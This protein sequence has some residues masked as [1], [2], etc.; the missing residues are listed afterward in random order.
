MLWAREQNM[1]CPFL[2]ETQVKH[3]QASPF[4]K[5]IVQSAEPSGPERCS[6]PDHVNC[7][8]ARRAGGELPE[9]PRCPFL[10]TSLVQFCSAASITKYIPYSDSLLSRCGNE[11]HRYCDLYLG[12]ARPAEAGEAA[13]APAPGPAEGE[14][15]NQ[16]PSVD[17]VSVPSKMA[18]SPN[19]MW[20]D[21]GEDGS[22]HIGVDG[23]FA[24]VIGQVDRI[25][26]IV[27]KG[28]ARPSAIVSVNGIDLQMIFPNPVRITRSNACLRANPERLVTHPYSL[29]WLFEGELDR[30]GSEEEPGAGLMR[31]KT[32]VE[33]MRLEMERMARFIHDRCT[34]TG[35][36]GE[37]LMMDGGTLRMGLAAHLNREE[38]FVLFNE[39]FAFYT[40][41]RK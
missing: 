24:R 3:C 37:N 9:A 39:F 6:S 8:A 10:Q 12:L 21:V 16:E 31:G 36:L 22:C 11:N 38:I 33:W 13:G 30:A 25:S 5:M 23:F 32:A 40:S 20:L 18:F 7:P 15:S 1:R 41:W 14:D 2:K 28:V 34:I 4:R 27:A 19:H 26:S 17:G 29:G 35:A